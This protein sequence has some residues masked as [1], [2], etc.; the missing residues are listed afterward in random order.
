MRN[1]GLSN[2]DGANFSTATLNEFQ[3]NLNGKLVNVQNQ[4]WF[5]VVA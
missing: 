4:N 5:Y 3:G 1:E 2:F